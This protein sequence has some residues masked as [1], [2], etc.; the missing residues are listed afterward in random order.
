MGEIIELRTEGD[1]KIVRR[2]FDVAVVPE[3]VYI[4]NPVCPHCHSHSDGAVLEC[5][6]EYSVDRPYNTIILAELIQ[7]VD[8]AQL[9]LVVESPILRH[10]EPIMTKWSVPDIIRD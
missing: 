8:C 7:C 2:V 9:A 6:E 4:D 5:I 1:K 3:S 10:H